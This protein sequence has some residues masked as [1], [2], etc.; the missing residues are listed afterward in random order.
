MNKSKLKLLER[1]AFV[2]LALG[3]GGG[4]ANHEKI[5]FSDEPDVQA[6]IA[7]AVAPQAPVGK[8][9]KPDEQAIDRLVF[10]DLLGRHFWDSGEYTA[11]FVQAD[12]QQVEALMQQFPQHQP[13]IKM[14]FHANLRKNQTPL[15]KDTGK[16]AMILSTEVSE[17]NADDSVDVIG[18]WY[19]GN[20]VTGFYTYVLKKTG[21]NWQVASV[22]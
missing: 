3:L 18:R 5:P 4:C 11:V 8:L 6:A 17:P 21:G 12:D 15:D 9:S 16:P 22:K 19:A 13:P 20:S 10:A 14:S 1:A 2:A 7:N